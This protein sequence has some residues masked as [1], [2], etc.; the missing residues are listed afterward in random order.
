MPPL[1]PTQT[2]T[3][4][5]TSSSNH[6]ITKRIS[7]DQQSER[8][9]LSTASHEDDASHH[10]VS[11]DGDSGSFDMEGRWQSSNY[12][13]SSLSDAQI[14]KLQKKGIN[15]SLYAEMKAARKGKKKVIG[16]LLGNSFLG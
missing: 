3:S 9:S 16:P 12:D 2:N 5:S 14:R 10:T 6:G 15:P 7:V 4:T 13:T 11:D 8:I 1:Q